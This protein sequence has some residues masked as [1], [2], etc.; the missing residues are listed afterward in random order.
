MRRRR[1]RR[2][3]ARAGGCWRRSPHGPDAVGR[4]AI[5]ATRITRQTVRGKEGGIYHVLAPGP[6]F[7]LAPALRLD[8]ALNLRRGT[9]GRLAVTLLAWNALAALLVGAMF[10]LAARRRAAAPGSRPRSRP[11]RR[12]LPPF[13]FYSFQFYPEMLGAL[14]MTA[15]LR[16]LL[17]GRPAPR[18]ARLAL[19]LALASLPWLHQKFL[20]VWLA[21]A[22]WALVRAVSDLVP[23]R[24]VAAL[25]LP[26]AAS[27]T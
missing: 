18:A 5:R 7:L 10:Q 26:Q 23:F 8:R 15:A 22:A 16:A 27:C 21:L 6:S 1:P 17:F 24:T 25:V 9:P 11:A 2:S 4:D 12:S 14:V 20:P 13:V 19:G 3:R